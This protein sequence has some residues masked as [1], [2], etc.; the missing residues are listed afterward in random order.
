[1]PSRH[2]EWIQSIYEIAYTNAP[3]SIQIKIPFPFV[4]VLY[5]PISI[6]SCYILP[7]LQFINLTKFLMRSSLM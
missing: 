5:A 4:S 2:H 1:M 7:F 3:I 6:F